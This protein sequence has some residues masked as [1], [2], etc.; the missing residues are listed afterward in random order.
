MAA[1]VRN[2][3]FRVRLITREVQHVSRL[4]GVA[5]CVSVSLDAGVMAALPGH[6]HQWAGMEV[7]YSLVLPPLPTPELAR[8]RPQY[9]ALHRRLGR[10]LV[11]RENLNSIHALDFAQ[12]TFG[13]SG[14]VFVP[15]AL[16]L[17]GRYLTTVD[18]AGRDLIQDHE[19]LAGYLM[20][21]PG[22]FLFG[23]FVKHLVDPAVHPEYGDIDVIAL[24][25][26]VMRV[27]ADR[28]GFAFTEVS[29]RSYPR[30]FLGKS[31]R[32]GKPVQLVLMDSGADALRFVMSAQY[33]ADRVAFSD[34]TYH[35]DGASARS[36]SGMRSAPSGPAPWAAPATS[37]CSTTTGP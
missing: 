1:T 23:G 8:L 29:T 31:R 33:D 35:F 26:G 25:A 2:H 3:G 32:A 10:R 15:K 27:L 9:A 4:R 7:E 30:Y 19:A 37:A 34:G 28:F 22:V 17:A 18:C 24:D 6:A 36:G 14:I 13:H 20:S 11:L 12:L 5:D 21:D 16:C